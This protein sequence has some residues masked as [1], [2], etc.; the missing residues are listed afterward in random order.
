MPGGKK[1]SKD[2]APKDAPKDAKDEKK[3]GG[4]KK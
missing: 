1:D 3:A 2:A 4:K